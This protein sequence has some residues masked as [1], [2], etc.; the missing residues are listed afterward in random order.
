MAT[1]PAADNAAM[2]DPCLDVNFL[3][4]TAFAQTGRV[5]SRPRLERANQ[6][7]RQTAENSVLVR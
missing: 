6:P 1:R 7:P 5:H 3:R 4:R 2:A